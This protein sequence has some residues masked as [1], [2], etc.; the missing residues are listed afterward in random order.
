MEIE[1]F[2]SQDYNG[3]KNTFLIQNGQQI[4]VANGNA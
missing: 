2:G 1:G 4:Q 3:V